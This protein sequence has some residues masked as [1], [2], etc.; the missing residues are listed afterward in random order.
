MEKKKKRRRKKRQNN[1]QKTE[2]A[3]LRAKKIWSSGLTS[4]QLQVR[5]ELMKK[6]AEKLEKQILQHERRAIK[7][8]AIKYAELGLSVF[9]VNKKIP[10]IQWKPYQTKRATP[11]EISQWWQKWPDAQ[12]AIVTG[13]ISNLVVLD[14]DGADVKERF[15]AEVCRIPETIMQK[16]G[17]VDG[18]LHCLF[19]YP[20]EGIRNT[21]SQILKNVD[22]K[23]EGGYFIVA[24]SKHKSGKNYKWLNFD[25]FK[26]GLDAKKPL[27]YEVL[28]WWEEYKKNKVGTD[29]QH[30]D[31]STILN[32]VP[33]GQRDESLF[34]YACRLRKQGL[35]KDE[36][37]IIILQAAS[38]CD[39]PFP[40]NEAIE[41]VE[42]AWKYSNSD[43]QEVIDELNKK[44]AVVMLGGKCV[45]MNEVI[46][47][48]F[49]RPDV[50]FSTVHDFRIR[51]LNQKIENPVKGQGH[52]K[53][54]SIAKLFLESPDRREYEGIVFNPS[55]DIPNYY[56]LY[57]GLAVEPKEGDWS[58]FRDNIR[59]VIANRW[60][61]N[62]LWIMA[63]MARLF[64]DPGGKRPGTA[65]VLRGKQGVGKSFFA[66]IF[67][68][69]FGSH[70]LHITNQN[71]L[72]GRF[73]N[74]LKDA[75]LVFCDEGIWAGDKKA[76]GV[77]KGMV[78]EDVIMV[79]PKGKDVFPVKNHVNLIIASN[80]DWVIPAGLEERR[81]FVLDVSEKY[82]QDE[83]YFKAIFDQ[84]NKGGLEAMLFD[85]LH[86]DYSGVDLRTFPRT[87]ALLDQ[88]VQSASSVKKFWF[89][90]L[91]EGALC[92]EDTNW[93]GSVET[94]KLYDEYIDYC[95]NI[96]ER[97]P[98]T[99]SQFAKQLRELCS[100][101]RRRRETVGSKRPYVLYLPPLEECR[102]QFEQLV[103]MGINWDED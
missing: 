85:L 7:N 95:R 22:I 84:M 6:E 32:G 61:S 3:K 45:V 42:S 87:E 83:R 26:D 9:P 43:H 81:F 27:P 68:R 73:N 98:Q 102:I 86:Y 37:Q 90:R 33:E 23:G 28:E 72:T 93:N 74:H 59:D 21:S 38:A 40:E 4:E 65:I 18:G 66:S 71:Q 67:K 14:F 44:H 39:P 53:K 88:I 36:V 24:P 49:N 62:F 1:E 82:M 58:L 12:I 13:S 70:F 91:R 48:G 51:Y 79:E 76:E 34:K 52:S 41:K 77:L 57:R 19:S 64:Q 103:N 20:A 69:I 75:L 60:R 80:N 25:P 30:L 16:T 94:K 10:C 100:G 46:D 97:Y 101:I 50:T 56:N 89:E 15:E 92:Y 78:T 2:T 47:P 8:N 35:S 96:G 11:D 54:I 99:N 5:H 17:R 31:P 55:G 63:W 29:R